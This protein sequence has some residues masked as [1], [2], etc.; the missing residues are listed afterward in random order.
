M[1]CK[2]CYSD[3]RYTQPQIT[4]HNNNVCIYFCN[5]KCYGKSRR[6]VVSVPV[7]GIKLD[8]TVRIR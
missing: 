3:L 6:P 8:K 7:E 2:H 5:I 4:V 1:I